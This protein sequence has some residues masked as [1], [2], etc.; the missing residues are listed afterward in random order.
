MEIKRLDGTQIPDATRLIWSTFCQFD[1]PDYSEEGIQ[2]FRSLIHN[3][4]ILRTME[5]WG[6][7]RGEELLGVI[8]SRENRSHICFFFV[9]AQCQ[10]QGIGKRLWDYFLRNSS[11]KIITVNSAPYA[12]PVYHALGFSDMDVQ[13][14]KSG[15]RSTPMRFER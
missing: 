4:K 2:T 8:A 13:Q 10:R 1:A 3:E 15:I 5:F 12:V 7:F 6:A 9:K 11:A 14:I